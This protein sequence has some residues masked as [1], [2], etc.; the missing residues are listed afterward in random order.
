M[1]LKTD[2]NQND[3]I[4][5]FQDRILEKLNDDKGKMINHKLKAKKFLL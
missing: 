4:K 1:F 3:F 5:F 2:E